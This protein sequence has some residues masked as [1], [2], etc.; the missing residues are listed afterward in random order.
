MYLYV[1]KLHVYCFIIKVA[2][3]F[4]K[5]P[6]KPWAPNVCEAKNSELSLLLHSA[7]LP[8]LHPNDLLFFSLHSQGY[9]CHQ[10]W[11]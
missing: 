3:I 9:Q 2:V 7:D 1:C 5:I 8:S 4:L 11:L 6:L 10:V